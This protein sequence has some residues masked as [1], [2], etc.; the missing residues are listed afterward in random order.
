[1]NAEIIN[2]GTELLMGDVV[3]TN[4]TFIAKHL[5]DYGIN[6]YFQTVI[7]DNP[8][9][10]EAQI[11]QS[12]SRSDMIIIT[13]GLGPTYDDLTKEIVAQALNLEMVMDLASK[14]RI[15]SYFKKSHRAMPHNNLKQAMIPDGSRALDNNYGTAPGV[16]IEQNDKT[17]ILLPGPPREL[18]PMFMNA[19]I[20][21]LAEKRDFMIVSDRVYIQGI[22]ES[23]IE[24]A[25]SSLMIESTNPTIAPYLHE[26]G[27]MLRVSARARSQEEGHA[28]NQNA[29]NVI[30]ETFPDNIMGVNIGSL[31]EELVLELTKRNQ[32]IATA[33][34]C[35][36]GLLA[37]RITDV[38][39]SSAIFNYGAVTYSNTMKTQVLGVDSS[40][41]DS[42][43]AVS[44]EVAEA[45]ALGV[46][47]L[48][49]ADYGIGITGIAGPT[50]GT[51]EKPVG[52]VYIALATTKGCVTEK[53]M[54]GHRHLDRESV[55]YAA[56]QAALALI[57]K[58]L[59]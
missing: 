7:G 42:V 40:L 15:E 26:N 4:A 38:N 49:N 12:L 6:N 1:M 36:G 21:F 34:S 55:R 54:F 31:E 29:V 3:N 23:H 41:F 37:K 11:K 24:E 35:T 14:E 46:K 47:K 16:L 30:L 33:E 53:Y 27:V 13:G 43:G 8:A 59:K 57:H 25:L 50:G 48:A 9:R 17:V 39:G 52:T 32:T 58:H 18:K 56:S 22:G 19:I 51:V 45:M 28:L 10:L 5:Q 20:P 44:K 2:V